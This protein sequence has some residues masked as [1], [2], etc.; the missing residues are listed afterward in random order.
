M[1]GL[2]VVAGIRTC[3]GW[4]RVECPVE[5][6][7]RERWACAPATSPLLCPI[8][9]ALRFSGFPRGAYQPKCTRVRPK[10][11]PWFRRGY[12]RSAGRLG[13]RSVDD[14]MI[15]RDATYKQVQN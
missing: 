5:G 11:H 8:E 7:L 9:K 13:E 10:P 3:L 15:V 12:R 2:G 14:P 4:R 1:A 6:M